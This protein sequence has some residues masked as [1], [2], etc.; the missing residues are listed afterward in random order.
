MNEYGLDSHYF[1][2][3]LRC[4]VRDI[5]QYTPNEMF[6]EL[7]RLMMVSAKQ[8]NLNVEVK[9]KFS[10]EIKGGGERMNNWISV[11]EAFPDEFGLCLVLAGERIRL[12]YFCIDGFTII[13]TISLRYTASNDAVTSWQSL[14]E[15]STLDELEQL[16]KE[17]KG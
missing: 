15:E 1:E 6:N 7:S 12:A 4:I 8:A 17:V 10:G 9:V 5:Q 3:K 11:K 2:K 14:K 16:I 13:D